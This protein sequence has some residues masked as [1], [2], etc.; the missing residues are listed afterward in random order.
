METLLFLDLLFFIKCAHYT[1]L[2]IR[3]S[4][5]RNDIQTNYSFIQKSNSQLWVIDNNGIAIEIQS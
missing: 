1:L 2:Q 3:I 4:V 5:V